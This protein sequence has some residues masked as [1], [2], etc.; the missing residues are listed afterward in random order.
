MVVKL[1]NC[2]IGT[3]IGE[4]VEMDPVIMIVVTKRQ[5]RQNIT[6]IQ[7]KGARTRGP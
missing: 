3:Q 5:K 4:V 7:K 6:N 1:K 2:W